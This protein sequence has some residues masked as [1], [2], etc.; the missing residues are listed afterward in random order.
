MPNTCPFV[1]SGDA[2]CRLSVDHLRE[3][4]TGPCHPLTVV[5]CAE[6]KHA[7]TIY[8]RGHVPWGRLAVV[9]VD[10][11]GELVKNGEPEKDGELLKNGEHQ[12]EGT[13]FEAAAD[14]AAGVAWARSWESSENGCWTSQNRL[15]EL[16]LNVLGLGPEQSTDLRRDI[17]EVLGVDTIVLLE[18][19][20]RMR[21]KPGYRCCGEAVVDVLATA[22]KLPGLLKRLLVTGHLA[23]CWGEPLW[24]DVDRKVLRK[25]AFSCS[26][27]DPPGG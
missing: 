18:W 6:H 4:K 10:R 16:G 9:Y 20:K 26:G 27:T 17:G 7:F 13:I 14:A 24:W 19:A 21:E 1:K 23:G 25:L 12:W 22:A 5:R 11:D 3:R 15:I 8:P 2:A